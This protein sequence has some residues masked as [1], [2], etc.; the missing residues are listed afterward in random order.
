VQSSWGGSPELILVVDDLEAMRKFC[1]HA[2]AQ[3]GYEVV[4]AASGGEALLLAERSGFD[5]LLADLTMPGMSGAA[6]AKALRASRPALPA[7]YMSGE[8]ARSDIPHLLPHEAFLLK[9]F[10]AEE[11]VARVRKLLR[12]QAAHAGSFVMHL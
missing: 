11:L 2:L 4:E 3:A 6:L 8:D 10:Q 1:A 7:L 12:G 5:L 9:P